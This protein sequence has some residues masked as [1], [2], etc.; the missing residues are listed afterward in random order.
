MRS[1]S[2]R[3]RA[4]MRGQDILLSR[5][6]RRPARRKDGCHVEAEV[7]QRVWS[8]LPLRRRC[9]A[10]G[11]SS[12]SVFRSSARASS[13]LQHLDRHRGGLWRGL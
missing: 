3:R 8:S 9:S 10:D 1:S 13:A 4:P 11:S 7:E 2:S 6:A 12:S 5:C